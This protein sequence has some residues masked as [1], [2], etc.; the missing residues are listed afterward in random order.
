MAVDDACAIV[1][2][3]PRRFSD[4]L[5]GTTPNARHPD[6]DWSVVGYVSHVGDSIRIWAERVASVALGGLGPI[7]LYDQDLLASARHYDDIDPAAALWSLRRAVLDWQ[8]SLELVGE[9]TFVM[10][11]E[12]LGELTLDEVIRIRAHDV[13]HHAW[14]VE[15]TIA[16]RA[17]PAVSAGAARPRSRASA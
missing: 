10:R 8:A 17:S 4:V 11:H 12:E 3:S 2:D 13:A 14:D 15:R 7:A 1:D 9:S 6:L 16:R 5:S